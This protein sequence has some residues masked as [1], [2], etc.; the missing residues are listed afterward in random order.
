VSLDGAPPVE[1]HADHALNP[2]WSNDG[3]FLV[4]SGADLGPGF[5]LRAI[6]AD[7]S[8]RAMPEITLSR[9]ARRVRFH[10]TRDA[11]IVL[12]GEMRFG[13]LWLIDLETGERQALTNFGRE[14]SIR[15]FDVSPDGAEFI[16]DRRQENSDV[17]VIELPVGN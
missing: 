16:F 4:Y 14:S 5:S 15:D 12:L 7:G 9:A 13:N 2:V 6:N 10:P 11:L 8:A 3:K 1:M 17:A